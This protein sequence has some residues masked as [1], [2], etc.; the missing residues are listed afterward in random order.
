MGDSIIFWGAFSYQDLTKEYPKVLPN[1]KNNRVQFFGV[2]GLKLDKL[3]EVLQAKLDEHSQKPTILILHCGTNAI[4]PHSE[5]NT[6]IVKLS[7]VL[8]EVFAIVKKSLSGVKVI[9]SDI[10]QRVDYKSLPWDH[11][12][13]YTNNL[14][15]ATQMCVV[16]GGHTFAQHCTI[17]GRKIPVSTC[18]SATRQGTFIPPR[19]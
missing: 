2:R 17:D 3:T 15:A 12:I 19:L 14:N 6:L 11:G 7:K 8:S 16:V 9:W 10:L 18:P 13:M 4:N 5:V 1:L